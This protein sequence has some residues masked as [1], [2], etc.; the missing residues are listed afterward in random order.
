VRGIA[1]GGELLVLM[2]GA[3]ERVFQADEVRVC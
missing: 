3:V 2:D 1:E